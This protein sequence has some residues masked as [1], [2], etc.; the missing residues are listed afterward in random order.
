MCQ[1]CSF[2]TVTTCR[3][4]LR[5]A[6]RVRRLSA[7]SK[8]WSQPSDSVYSHILPIVSL[9]DN[10]VLETGSIYRTR[11]TKYRPLQHGDMGKKAVA[12]GAP[13]AAH[14]SYIDKKKKKRSH[15]QKSKG[16]DEGDRKIMRD[17]KGHNGD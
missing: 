5:R 16:K 17:L 14:K 2:G 10:D 3:V 9:D 7:Q 15:H 6:G 4:C 8:D 13:R 12:A 1:S 11:F